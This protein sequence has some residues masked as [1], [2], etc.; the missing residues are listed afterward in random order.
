MPLL[1]QFFTF[2]FVLGVIILIIRMIGAWMLRID[3]IITKMNQIIKL[4]ESLPKNNP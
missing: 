2:L 3:E 1:L 4:L